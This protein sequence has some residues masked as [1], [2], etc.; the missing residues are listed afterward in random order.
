VRL[1]TFM[2]RGDGVDCARKR[3]S[4]RRDRRARRRSPLSVRAPEGAAAAPRRR[5]ALRVQAPEGAAA[6]ARRR[7]AL[8]VQAPEGAAAA[9]TAQTSRSTL[10][11]PPARTGRPCGSPRRRS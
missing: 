5:S 11:D 9:A 6:A 2:R 1:T 7:S 4:R 10:R 3:R 8:R